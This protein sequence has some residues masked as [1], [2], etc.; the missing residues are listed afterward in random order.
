MVGCPSVCS[1]HTL[2]SLPTF[3]GVIW[4]SGEKRQAAL[5]PPY[6]V[7]SAPVVTPEGS[8]IPGELGVGRAAIAEPPVASRMMKLA[9][10]KMTAAATPP[11]AK[12]QRR[13]SPGANVG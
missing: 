8:A 4:V 5:V 11:Q 10:T 9:T 12:R 3:S 2:V 13:L 1:S 7:H 6:A